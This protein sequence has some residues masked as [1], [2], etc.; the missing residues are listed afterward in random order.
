M[1]AT[2]M[3][4]RYRIMTLRCLLAVLLAAGISSASLGQ[5][6]EPPADKRPISRDMTRGK[7]WLLDAAENNVGVGKAGTYPGYHGT[8]NHVL[9]NQTAFF[10]DVRTPTQDYHE[11]PRASVA[12]WCE[13]PQQLVKNYNFKLSVNEPEEYTVGRCRTYDAQPDDEFITLLYEVYTKRMVWSLPK[14]DDFVIWKMVVKNN[15]TRPWTDAYIG[16][17]FVVNPSGA[18]NSRFTNDNEYV[19]AS[20]L[21]TYGDQQ[22]AF[23]F[24]DDVSWPN[25]SNAPAVYLYPPGDQTGDRGDPGNILEANSVDRRLYSPQAVS[26][27]FLDA[28]PNKNGKKKFW[29]S[30][31]NSEGVQP[32]SH[33]NAPATERL[34]W[35]MSGYQESVNV[36]TDDAPRMSW[37][38]ANAAKLP[39]AGNTWERSPLLTIS[40]GPYDVAPGDSV[41]FMMLFVGGELDRN[42]AMRGGYEATQLLPQAAIDDVKKNWASAVEIIENG[43]KPKAYPPPT[44][45]NVPR[46]NHGDELGVEAFSEQGADGKPSQGYILSWLPVPDSYRDPRTGQNDFAGY[47]IYRSTVGTEGP[48]DKMK[49]VTRAEAAG[50][51]SGGRVVL[52]LESDPGIP[53]RFAVTSFDTEGLESGMTAYSLD[54]ISAPRASTNDLS[55]VLVVPNPFRQVSGLLDT[56]EEKRLEFVNIPSQCTIRIYTMAGELINTIEHDGFGSDAWG[57]SSGDN[58]NYMLTKWATN[59]SPGIYLYHITS[60][61]PGH[62]GETAAG[63]FAILK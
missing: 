18:G 11:W 50:M 28:K 22:G 17:N 2:P 25:F 31:R 8:R 62:E 55:R 57:S 48:W 4:K 9:H 35:A 23:I 3:T 42:I 60:S 19:W 13:Q 33:Q 20:D 14:Y 49:E 47:R 1:W 58:N 34:V 21:K 5:R 46:E 10:L 44:P 26:V 53:S 27:G 16:Y 32:W 7:F 61:V 6:I 40:I 36:M 52:K 51:V 12:G 59:V 56:G 30:I 39:S 37:K 43:Y 24:Y 38:E 29:Y 54:P 15:D 45:G 63:K 41:E